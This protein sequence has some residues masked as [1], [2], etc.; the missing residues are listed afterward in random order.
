MKNVDSEIALAVHSYTDLSG[1]QGIRSLAKE[2][3]AAALR[4]IA[5]QFESMMMQMMLKSMRSANAMF[6]EGNFL[7]SS[8][9][10]FYQGML[11]DQLTLSLSAGN[12]IGIADAMVHQLMR[13]YGVENAAHKNNDSAHD[14]TDK[15]ADKTASLPRYGLQPMPPPPAPATPVMRVDEQAVF[16]GS[17]ETFVERI[18]SVAEQAAEK[19]G[20]DVK[21]IVAQAALET[22]WGAKMCR[23]NN[24]MAS[25]N[26]FNIKADGGWQ[27]DR[28]SVQTVE[29]RDGLMVREPAQFRAYQS[30]ADSVND[31]VDFIIGSPRYA[32]AVAARSGEDYL[33]CLSKAGYATDPDYARKVASIAHSDD[34]NVLLATPSAVGAEHQHDSAAISDAE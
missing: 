28:V 11:D 9:S 26:L 15:S 10:D 4:E 24:G 23:G 12:G 25:H 14:D 33:N 32:D 19:L 1:I 16:D 7:N 21:W 20:V 8:E 6:A 5:G 30:L 18:R 27:G 31:Y 13:N 17:K 29:Y 2:D 34:L 3:K 22:G